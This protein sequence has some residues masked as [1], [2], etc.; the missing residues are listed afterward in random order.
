MQRRVEPGGGRLHGRFD[1]IEIVGEQ[2]DRV[3]PGGDERRGRAQIA[4]NRPPRPVVAAVYP[5]RVAAELR[6]HTG[7][8]GAAEP[9]EH[10]LAGFR[11]VQDVGNDGVGRHFGAVVMREVERIVLAGRNVGGETGNIGAGAAFLRLGI[12][13]AGDER[14]RT[15]RKERRQGQ[16]K[17][18]LGSGHRHAIYARHPCKFVGQCA[19]IA[20]APQTTA[21]GC[22]H[23]GPDKVHDVLTRHYRRTVQTNQ[24][25]AG[26]K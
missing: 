26:A 4:E 3:G 9:V 24:C 7:H 19:L 23:A 15:C 16:I 6:C 14:V 5:G 10:H 22:R 21:R 17:D 8:A 11:V 18:V 20:V 2:A 12:E 13:L 25:R 1:L